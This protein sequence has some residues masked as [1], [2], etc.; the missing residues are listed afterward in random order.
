MM[1]LWQVLYDRVFKRE[2]FVSHSNVDK[3]DVA[4]LRRELERLGFTP[5]KPRPGQDF[6]QRIRRQI[7]KSS[8]AVLVETPD[9]QASNEVGEE[10]FHMVRARINLIPVLRRGE[11]VRPDLRILDWVDFVGIDLHSEQDASR[12]QEKLDEINRAL[13]DRTSNLRG[14]QLRSVLLLFLVP[15]LS[16]LLL[17]A[18]A[19]RAFVETVQA[20]VEELE[21]YVL[22][23]E[24]RLPGLPQP[25]DERIRLNGTWDYVPPA[26][27]PVPAQNRQ[28][29]QAER[30]LATDTWEDGRLRSRRFFRAGVLVATDTYRFAGRTPIE[31]LRA[32]SVPGA[33]VT[34]FDRFSS[35]GALTQRLGVSPGTGKIDAMAAL[36][37]RSPLPP[38]WMMLFYR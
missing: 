23:A 3:P 35:D 8:G 22:Q 36:A 10:V 4:W 26:G 37:I 28:E 2:V 34:V 33:D 9:A 24:A 12:R 27:D 16:L 30:P 31:R 17:Q 15:G 1:R 29:R 14:L 13:R 7:A 11:S 18:Y 5:N 32:Y 21:G 19:A 38:P 6:R 20:Q 25:T